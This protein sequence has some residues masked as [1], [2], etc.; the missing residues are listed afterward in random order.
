MTKRW[1]SC[2][3]CGEPGIVRYRR[4]IRPHT[5]ATGGIRRRTMYVCG[6][7]DFEVRR[8]IKGAFDLVAVWSPAKGPAAA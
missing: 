5:S 3:A 2:V 8:L 7:H 4:E 1:K 6:R